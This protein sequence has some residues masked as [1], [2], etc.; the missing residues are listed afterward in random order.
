MLKQTPE[1]HTGTDSSIDSPER[2]L[3]SDT[4]APDEIAASREKQRTRLESA[5][6]VD[7]QRDAQRVDELEKR[8]HETPATNKERTDQAR[9]L[10]ETDEA[11]NRW[12]KLS[13]SMK[14]RVRISQLLVRLAGSLQASGDLRAQ[15]IHTRFADHPCTPGGFVVTC[16]RRFAQHD[17][18]RDLDAEKELQDSF[19]SMSG[20]DR[21][22]F[23]VWLRH[24]CFIEEQLSGVPTT[25]VPREWFP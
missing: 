24:L 9:R 21:L 7:R 11:N 14:A 16:L 5:E 17:Y 20:F 22:L 1:L 19:R 3:S 12:R 18:G 10:N 23:G 2:S 25:S 15:P 6:A 13:P 8:L 4:R